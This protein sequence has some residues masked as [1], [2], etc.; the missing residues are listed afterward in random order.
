M[1]ESKRTGDKG[2]TRREALK[3]S[4][5]ALGG[6]AIGGALIGP[7]HGRALTGD[8][9]SCTCPPGPTCSWKSKGRAQRYSYFNTLPKFYPFEFSN[10][11]TIA[12]LAADQ[13][14]ITFMGSCFPPPRKAQQL[15]SV[16][17][18][19]GWD[20]EKPL[21]Q[22]VFDCGS[23]VV[24]N[25]G[26]MNVGLGRMDKV[27]IAHIH[28]DHMSDLTHIYGFGP[29]GDRKSPL[30]VW[31]P[32]R[33]N[34]AWPDPDTGVP[35]PT[36]KDGTADYCLALRQANRWHTE[37]FSFQNTSYSTFKDPIQNGNWQV[38]LTLGNNPQLPSPVVDTDIY[39]NPIP[40]PYNDAYA[41]VP[42]E[43]D[44]TIVGGLAYKNT[45]TGVIITHFPVIHT[46][47]GAIGYKL[48]W[49]PSPSDTGD[50]T[51]N[52]LT[53]IYTSDTKPENNCVNQAINGGK[54]VDVLIHDMIVPAQVYTM[55]SAYSD[56]IQDF[57][58]DSPDVQQ[59]AT[60]EASS[61]SP[62]GSFGYLLSQINPQPRLTVATHFPVADDTVACAM[63]S[64]QE[65]FPDN[66]VYQGNNISKK[67]KNPVRITWSFDLMVI[68]VSK[69]KIVEQRGIVSDFGFSPWVNYPVDYQ[70]YMDPPK[71]WE[72]GVDSQGNPI[73]ASNPY[74]QIDTTTQLPECDCGTN[75]PTCNYRDDG[76]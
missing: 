46:R 1:E 62:Q 3:V 42:I 57:P 8:D 19:V 2:L 13:M 50:E 28:G 70:K 72:W 37:S 11:T 18:E 44:W 26:A 61:H 7:E 29:S 31:G 64:V 15:M 36:Y 23:G 58:V 10:S 66:V 76:Y 68:N 74:A 73:K 65:H 40:D 38:P 43:L 27:F 33:S 6:L 49:W 55:K 21:D 34:Y 63:K 67:A 24:A 39:G 4:G 45:T 16:F 47:R 32:G 17:V 51:K 20:G 12:P 48:E 35:G 9:C 59:L 54:G 75:P 25:Y 53:M 71:Y 5:L 69:D 41:L 30:Y 52:H 56:D 14:R 22:F 60:I